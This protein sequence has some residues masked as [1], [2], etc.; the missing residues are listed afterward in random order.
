VQQKADRADFG[1]VTMKG[2]GKSAPRVWQ[3]AWHG[4]PHLEQN[5][6]GAAYGFFGLQPGLVARATQQCMAQ[7]NGWLFRFGGWTEPG[8]QTLWYFGID[9]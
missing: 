6:I 1:H 2:C 4:K 7:M 5:Q 3:Q 9:R 8:L